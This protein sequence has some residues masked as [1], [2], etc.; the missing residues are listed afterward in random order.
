MYTRDFLCFLVLWF[1]SHSQCLRDLFFFCFYSSSFYSFRPSQTRG[2][3][4][5]ITLLVYFFVHF[6][7]GIGDL[8]KGVGLGD[9]REWCQEFEW[10][11]GRTMR[12]ADPRACRGG[13]CDER[14]K[15]R[16][17]WKEALSS[18]RAFQ[19]GSPARCLFGCRRWWGG[20][21]GVEMAV[22]VGVV[23]LLLRVSLVKK[24]PV[25]L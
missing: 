15:L 21:G 22:A 18:P 13:V 10:V 4:L 23:F 24:N 16:N 14:I 3:A 20:R 7:R 25:G 12:G 6:L 11:F 17:P 5:Q 2:H 19:V 1:L 8:R 9:R